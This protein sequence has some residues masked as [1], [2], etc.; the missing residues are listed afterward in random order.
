[1][2]TSKN[3]NGFTL[4]ELAV[5]LTI[6]GLIIGGIL[7]GSSIIRSLEIQ[8]ALGESAEFTQA[9]KSFQDK[10]DA[11]PGD[12]SGATAIWGAAHA[13]AATCIITVGTT[14]TA[15]CNGDSNGRIANLDNYAVT[16]YEQFRAWQHLRNAKFIEGNFS[17]TATTAPY[18]YTIGTN[19]PASGLTGA[20]WKMMTVTMNDLLASAGS[21]ADNI[22]LNSVFNLLG[23]L[24]PNVI[25]W[26][27]GSHSPNHNM[28]GALTPVEAYALDKKI[29][30]GIPTRGKWVA[31]RSG[32]TCDTGTNAYRL[33]GPNA[34][35]NVCALIVK[36]GL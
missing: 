15:T 35:L 14:E 11:L 36:T 33:T 25:L 24:P 3:A 8:S 27:R 22:T 16:Y 7:I 18:T 5:V 12:F 23:E 4:I 30:D 17:G 29:D 28:T 34:S 6:I 13:A 1:M 32:S 20:G 31:Q 21:G 19:I 10:Y 2:L 9:I 26:L